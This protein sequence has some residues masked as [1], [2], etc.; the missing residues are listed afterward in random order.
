MTNEAHDHPKL[1]ARPLV[2]AIRIYQKMV[3]PSLGKNCRFTPTCSSYAVGALSRFGVIK[4]SWL[5][6]RRIGRCNPLVPAGYDPVP[7][8]TEH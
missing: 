3:S 7:T 8:A 6:I 2:G 5:A 4:G 1:M